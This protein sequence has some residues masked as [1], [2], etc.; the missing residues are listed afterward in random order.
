MAAASTRTIWFSSLLLCCL[1]SVGFGQ[2]A[3]DSPAGNSTPPDAAAD[4]TD[5]DGKTKEPVDTVKPVTSL[6]QIA[7][8]IHEA[9]QSRKFDVAAAAI[10]ASI[11][12]PQVDRSTVDYLLYLKGRALIETGDLNGAMAA[13]RRIEAEFAEGKWVSR[14]RFAQADVQVRGR[15]YQEAGKI[16]RKEA[17]RLLSRERKDELAGIYLEFADRYYEGVPSDDPAQVKQ[18][19]YAQAL[20]YYQEARSSARR[21]DCDRRSSSGMSAASK[22]LATPAKRSARIKH[23]WHSMAG[24]SRSR[25]VVSQ[26][27]SKRRQVID[28][29]MHYSKADNA[30]LPARSGKI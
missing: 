10:D 8:A 16:Y 13:F 11:N 2:P 6:P 23:F 27:P 20:T 14:A 15:D 21:S 28:W 12:D 9:M 17:E 22:R 19:D 29:P 5:T 3:G 24:K 30:K 26:R 7:P 4:A 25:E 1:V 18:P